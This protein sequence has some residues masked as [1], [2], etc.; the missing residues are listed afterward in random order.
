MPSDNSSPQA[1]IGVFDSGVGGLTILD[2]LCRQ[3]PHE[4]YV[5]FGDTLHMPYGSKQTSF[6]EPLI[7]KNFEWMLAAHRLKML[8]VACNTA[9]AILM[10]QTDNSTM[11]SLPILWAEPITPICEWIAKS[12]FRKVGVMATSATVSTHRY[13]H[14]MKQLN[15][16]VQVRSVVCDGLAEMSESG[17]VDSPELM[18]ML[19]RFLNPLIAWNMEALILGCTH[20]PHVAHRI[21]ALIPPSVKLLNPADFIGETIRRQLV[22]ADLLNPQAGF[23]MRTFYVSQAPEQF[24]DTCHRLPLNFFSVEKVLLA[25][26]P[27]LA[28]KSAGL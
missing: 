21:R 25:S 16:S 8:V 22:A 23:G 2:A 10:T 6:L 18:S 5:Y 4:D 1:P 27:T 26:P 19:Q 20:Y 17:D 13:P 24:Q 15:A 3:L 12:S 11:S 7:F 14:V 28:G 9:T